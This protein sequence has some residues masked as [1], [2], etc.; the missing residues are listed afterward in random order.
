MGGSIVNAADFEEG[1]KRMIVRKRGGQPG[2]QNAVKHGRHS[3]PVRAARHVAALARYEES[4][5]KSAEWVKLCPTTDY[6][7]I[8]D[9]IRWRRR[10]EN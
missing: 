9:R 7:A 4:K 3:A 6:G 1:V 5:R 8:V 2:N 10:R